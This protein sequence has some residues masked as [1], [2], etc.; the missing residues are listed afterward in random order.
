MSNNSSLTGWKGEE[1]VIKEVHFIILAL[2]IVAVNSCVIV[3]VWRKRIL[4]KWQNYLLVS[5]ALSDLSTGLVGLPI[6]FICSFA[7]S[8]NTACPFCSV[9][10]IFT[11]FISV[12]TILHLLIVTYERFMFIVY[13]FHYE[14]ITAKHV[15]F[16]L[17]LAVTWFI[18]LAVASV[19]FAWMNPSK[20]GETKN[21]KT[22]LYYNVITVILFLLIP[23]ILFIY[24]Y[25]SMF[26]VA[27]VHIRRQERLLTRLP[28]SRSPAE[29]N[30][31]PRKEARV[32]VIFILMWTTFVI[33]WGPYFAL[34]IIDEWKEK[35]I[36]PEKLWQAA[37]VLR[38]LTSLLNPLLYSFL[39]KDFCQALGMSCC[40]Q[41]SA[42]CGCCLPY[43][44]R[45]NRRCEVPLH[46]NVAQRL[47]D[48]GHAALM[49]Q[50]STVH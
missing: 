11:K 39:K 41:Q 43:D 20:C 9:A 25:V 7:I 18:S 40:V 1:Y 22:W 27:R 5:L 38:F 6:S 46:S 35:V 30:M 47:S 16:M 33:C 29:P 10:Y 34:A 37:D 45:F 21:A 17:I 49:T 26:L 31:A 32:A 28:E 12:S 42:S 3:T 50:T 14:R 19:P 4:H 13:P 23:M 15:R 48:N 2:L 24:A 44:K 8:P 36:V